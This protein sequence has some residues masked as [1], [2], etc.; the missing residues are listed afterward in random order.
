MDEKDVGDGTEISG[1]G[2]ERDQA[3]GRGGLATDLY[4]G[5]AIVGSFPKLPE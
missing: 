5:W 4:L 3:G 2:R 1:D